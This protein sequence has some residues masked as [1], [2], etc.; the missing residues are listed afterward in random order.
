MLDPACSSR[1]L[2]PP[3][4][5]MALACVTPA[6][7][8]CAVEVSEAPRTAVASD[9]GAGIDQRVA[10]GEKDAVAAITAITAVAEA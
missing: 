7:A 1:I 9:D 10:A 8:R 3:V 4:K 5:V 2:L 6:C